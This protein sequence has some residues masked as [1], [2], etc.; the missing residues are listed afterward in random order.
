MADIY[1]IEEGEEVPMNPEMFILL[2]MTNELYEDVNRF[3]EEKNL[4]NKF[5]VIQGEISVRDINTPEEEWTKG[6]KSLL[7]R[8]KNERVLFEYKLSQKQDKLM[9]ELNEYIYGKE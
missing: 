1:V 5:E 9:T 3:L 8:M 4:Q 7:L 6:I 2:Y